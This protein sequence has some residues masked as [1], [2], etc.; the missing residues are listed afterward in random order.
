MSEPNLRFKVG[1]RVMLSPDGVRYY[2]GVY[3]VHGA[4]WVPMFQGGGMPG[5]VAFAGDRPHKP[6]AD[7]RP[8]FVA[9][10]NGEHNSYREI[11][12]A[13]AEE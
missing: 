4:A 6:G 2:G 1:D 10:D 11:D 8:Y 13:L 5:T 3:G 12:L 9:W 7:P